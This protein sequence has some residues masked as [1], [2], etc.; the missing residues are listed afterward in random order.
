MV[1]VTIE[2][3]PHG[4]ESQKRTIGLINIMNDGTSPNRAI[5]NYTAEL[6]HAGRFYGKRKGVFKR[7]KV[8]GFARKI[9]SPYRLVFRVLRE[10]GE[11]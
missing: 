10:A 1:R 9:L 11:Q 3:V 6:M 2:L 5:G 4:D 7:A 8:R